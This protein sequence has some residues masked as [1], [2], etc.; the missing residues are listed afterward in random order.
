MSAT[1]LPLV[2]RGPD[3]SPAQEARVSTERVRNKLSAILGGLDLGDP[4]IVRRGADELLALCVE[5]E[6]R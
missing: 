4:A 3:V 5:A 2:A 6:R 1:E